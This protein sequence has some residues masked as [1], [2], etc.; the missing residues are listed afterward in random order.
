MNKLDLK[1]S[2]SGLVKRLKKQHSLDEAMAQAVGGGFE[3]FGVIESSLLRFYGLQRDDSLIDVG[4]G[5]GRLAIPLS[6]THAGPY[7]GTDLVPDLLQYARKRCARPDWR[8][9]SVDGVTIPATDG[10]ADMVCF[11][12]VFTHLLH[13][14][15]YLYLEEARRVL[16]PGGRIIFSFLEFALPG[17]WPA[18][19]HTVDDARGRGHH[20]LNVFIERAAIQAWAEHLD[21]RIE[22]VRDGTD[23][24]IPLE[25][26]LT[27]PSGIVLNERANLGQSVCVLVRP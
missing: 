5:S 2:Y 21:L 22:D 17:H 13:E 15:S 8:F 27:L 4:C 10:R 1:A 14:Q 6:K 18:F 16:R 23:H 3:A 20:P 7:L 26:P 12:S 25:Q 11:F 9:E 19:A 24:F